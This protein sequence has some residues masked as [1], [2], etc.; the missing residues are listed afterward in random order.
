ME[1]PGDTALVERARAGDRAA[2]ASLV[3]RH[4]AL[5]AAVCRRAVGPVLVE[6][7]VQEAVLTAMIRLD[8]LRQPERFGAWLAGIG[9][10]FCRFWLRERAR[11]PDPWEAHAARPEPADTLN[12]A[13][14]AV[15]GE[16]AARVRAAV[17]ALPR[18]QRAAVLLHYVAGLSQAEA[19]ATLGVELGAVKTRLHKARRALRTPLRDL[20]TEEKTV[21]T[22]ERAPGM[23]EVV[24]QAVRLNFETGQRA[25]ILAEKD[26]ER[27]LPIWVG[28]ADADALV[29]S[30]DKIEIPRPQTHDFALSMLRAAGARVRSVTVDRLTDEVFYATVNLL[31]PA[32]PAAIDARPSDAINAAVREGAPILV[33]PALFLPGYTRATAAEEAETTRTTQLALIGGIGAALAAARTAWWLRGS[34]AIELLGGELDR[35]HP[36]IEAVGWRRNRA[37][38]RRALTAAGFAVEREDDAQLAFRKDGQAVRFLFVDRR[39]DGRI[40]THGAPAPLW[41]DDALPDRIH[42]F[43]GVEVRVVDAR[44][45]LEERGADRT[46]GGVRDIA[47]IKA[48]RELLGIDADAPA[49]A[50]PPGWSSWLPPGTRA[51]LSP[52]LIR[53]LEL[54]RDDE[55]AGLGHGYVGT[56][57]LLLALVRPEAGPIARL[58]ADAGAD[59]AR[60]RATI[61]R[62]LAR[63]SAPASARR[64]PTPRV[65]T[66]MR[67]AADDAARRGH[68]RVGPAH[69]T[70][71]LLDEGQ[72]VAVGALSHLGVDPSRLRDAA[73]ASFGRTRSNH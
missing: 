49:R 73:E 65:R 25:I 11:G 22:E 16:I 51:A 5:L 4:Y 41:R 6:D 19:A 59:T 46:P 50:D 40:V 8:R 31:G 45:L 15:I 1:T 71:G 36:W 37:A 66:V 39:K 64:G 12:P 44:Q 28:Q 2:F 48:L 26:G 34:W 52:E 20:W 42:R 29:V 60:V 53:V 68:P 30:L 7:A 23:V 55:A 72:G 69:L 58:L 35:R 62:V 70:L 9:L 57:H 56:E 18:G 63:G 38:I 21:V 24:V 61:E 17:A 54:A 27:L 47:G 67:L 10:N 14:L 13:E 32:D 43:D 33:D 3:E